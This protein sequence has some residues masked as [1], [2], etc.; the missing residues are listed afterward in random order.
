MKGAEIGAEGGHHRRRGGRGGGGKHFKLLSADDIRD[1][2]DTVADIWS[3]HQISIDLDPVV[4]TAEM[5]SDM[6]WIFPDSDDFSESDIQQTNTNGDFLHYD[7]SVVNVYFVRNIQGL[8]TN[9]YASF[10]D[11]STGEPS[12]HAIVQDNGTSDDDA[13]T[14][15]HELGHTLGLAHVCTTG[16]DDPADT[17][18]L[19][20]CGETTSADRDHLMYPTRISNL[21]SAS[22]PSSGLQRLYS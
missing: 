6:A 20:E 11:V 15:A 9:A 22:R 4:G 8:T 3:P 16:G 12:D 2:F 17:L 13:R 7:P 21:I 14:I 18:F 10:G 1:L 5:E 19:R